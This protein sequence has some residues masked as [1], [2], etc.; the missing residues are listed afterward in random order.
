MFALALGYEDLVDHDALRPDPVLAATMG[1]LAAR[2]ADWPALRR[3]IDAAI[4]Q[5]RTAGWC[6]AA[7]Q[8]EIVALA[9]PLRLAADTGHALNVSVS[10][11]Q[12][13][14]EVAAELAAPLLRLGHDIEH[15]MAVR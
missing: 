11:S 4:G 10:S 14:A 7:W 3:E 15:A 9:M 12:P 8:P 2:R 1:K 6:A 13:L 5:V